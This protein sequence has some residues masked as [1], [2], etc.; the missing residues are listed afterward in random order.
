MKRLLIVEDD[1]GLRE[2]LAAALTA[3]EYEVVSADCG[4]AGLEKARA[5]GFDLLILDR[6][7]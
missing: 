3:E 2:T 7:S 5:G 1:P 6:P 4:E